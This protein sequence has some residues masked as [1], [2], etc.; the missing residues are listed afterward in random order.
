M[1][2]VPDRFKPEL[3]MIQLP[4]VMKSIIGEWVVL[5]ETVLMNLISRK[6]KMVYIKFAFKSIKKHKQKV[7]SIL[8]LYCAIKRM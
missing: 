3:G 5:Q 1:S 4:L 8:K 2:S 6:T 7:V